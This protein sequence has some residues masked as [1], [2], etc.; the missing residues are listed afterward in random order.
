MTTTKGEAP[1]SPLLEAST[2]REQGIIQRA[3]PGT[4][5]KQ[6]AL[7]KAPCQITAPYTSDVTAL[8]RR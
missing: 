4:F 1:P 6:Q 2:R 7:G 5:L 8:I 3:E